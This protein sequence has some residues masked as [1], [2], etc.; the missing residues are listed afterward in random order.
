MRRPG[1]ENGGGSVDNKFR[2]LFRSAASFM[3]L[4]RLADAAVIDV[5]ESFLNVTG[6]KREDVIGSKVT[7]L[8]IWADSGDRE[9]IVAELKREGQV[10]GRRVNVLGADGKVFTCLFYAHKVE[11][12]GAQCM[13]AEAIDMTDLEEAK[14]ALAESE[15]RLENLLEHLPLGVQGYGPDGIVIYWN[16]ASERIY[17]YAA[18][19]AVGRELGSLIIPDDLMPIYRKGL[20]E[21]ARIEKSCEFLPAGEVTLRRKDNSPVT[22]YSIHTAVCA[23]G[24]PPTLFCIDMDLSER[25]KME[26]AMSEREV[27]FRA[28]F[29]LPLAGAAITGP[30]GRWLTVNDRL[31]EILGYGREE[32]LATTWQALTPPEDLEKER[33][34]HELL[35]SKDKA[36]TLEKRYI[37]KDKSVIDV[38]VSAMAV[39]GSDETK[40]LFAVLVQDVTESKRSDAILRSKMAEVEQLNRFMMGRETRVIELKREIN[41]ILKKFGQP[42]RYSV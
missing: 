30:D 40:T 13:L 3:T 33:G 23:E 21:A 4:T 31:C 15:M 9:K 41:E 22:V 32:L 1:A 7:D 38:K 10:R 18:G 37:R 11:F 19:E 29:D 20:A 14:A 42:P 36:Q 6:L 27:L 34:S 5:S 25:L 24:K 35:F 39:R 17:G 2:D 8:N 28:F 16:R 12:E 26:R